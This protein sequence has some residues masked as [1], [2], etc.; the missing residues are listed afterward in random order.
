MLMFI[1][2]RFHYSDTLECQKKTQHNKQTKSLSTF[3]GKL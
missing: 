1:L 3:L 2:W